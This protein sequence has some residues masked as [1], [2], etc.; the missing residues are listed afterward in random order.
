MSLVDPAITRPDI[1]GSGQRHDVGEPENHECCAELEFHVLSSGWRKIP[2]TTRTSTGMCRRWPFMPC[3]GS[4][5]I[6]PLLAMRSAREFRL[7]LVTA[8]NLKLA[9]GLAEA[10]L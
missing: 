8:P 10:A 3:L 7:V 9:R 4:M 2:R 1:S 6:F 5:K